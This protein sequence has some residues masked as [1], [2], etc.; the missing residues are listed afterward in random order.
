M[1]TSLLAWLRTAAGALRTHS[2]GI[3]EF[4]QPVAFTINWN[5]ASRTGSLGWGTSIL[6]GTSLDERGTTG[7]KNT[8]VDGD[9]DSKIMPLNVP[10][11]FPCL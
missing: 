6:D 7:S 2:N 10:P 1:I 3:G 5:A 4:A 8:Y 9:P 11:I